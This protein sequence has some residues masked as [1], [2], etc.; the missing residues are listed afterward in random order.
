MSRAEVISALCV[1]W[2]WYIQ[3]H[4]TGRASLRAILVALAPDI[5]PHLADAEREAGE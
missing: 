1:W 4:R 5:E 2:G 3:C